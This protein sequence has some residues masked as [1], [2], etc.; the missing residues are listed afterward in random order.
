[1]ELGED[2][3]AAGAATS[4]RKNLLVTYG[5]SVMSLWHWLTDLVATGYL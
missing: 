3:A 2:R 1:M 5:V 4:Y